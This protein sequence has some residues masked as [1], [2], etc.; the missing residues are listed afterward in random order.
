MPDPKSTGCEDSEQR[1]CQLKM[2]HVNSQNSEHTYYPIDKCGEPEYQY[3][4][5]ESTSFPQFIF[6]FINNHTAMTKARHIIH[7][8][9]C[10]KHP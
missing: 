2:L 1:I 8:F 10:F 3:V 9:T 4:K 7:Y 5:M 6:L